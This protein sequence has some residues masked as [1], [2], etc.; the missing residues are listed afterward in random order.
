MTYKYSLCRNCKVCEIRTLE[1]G[2]KKKKE[3][4]YC[5]VLDYLID[6]YDWKVAGK[7]LIT[8][9]NV[10]FSKILHDELE[11]E[12]NLK[13]EE[14]LNV[15]LK[16]LFIYK[17]DYIFS[18]NDGEF[19]IIKDHF[20]YYKC[21]TKKE[22][23]IIEARLIKNNWDFNKTFPKIRTSAHIV[24]IGIYHYVVDFDETDENKMKILYKCETRKQ[25]K[26]WRDK[27]IYIH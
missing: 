12:N 21:D 7:Y 2:K 17:D 9:N 19:A 15:T 4:K 26:S 6:K 25:A 1:L 13:Y 24:T 8:K 20:C 3:I 10:S 16:N 18:V 11:L 5:R 27:N 23:R 22:A 14:P